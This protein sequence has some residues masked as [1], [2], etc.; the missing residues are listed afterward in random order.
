MQRLGYTRSAY[1]AD[2]LLS[3]PDTFVRAPRPGM[4][5]ATAIVHVSPA[6]GAG[7][8]Q[9]TAEFEAGGLLGPAS[10]ERFLYV[11]EGQGQIGRQG[12]TP[13]GYP[14]PPPRRGAPPTSP[15]RARGPGGG[16]GLPGPPLPQIRRGHRWNPLTN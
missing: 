5:Q 3:T 8:T 2:H 4:R 9:Y 11:L 12:P 14:H 10:G 7:F 15:R 16:G 13:G 1:R 6:A